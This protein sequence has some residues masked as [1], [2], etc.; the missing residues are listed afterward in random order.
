MG[1]IDGVH[2]PDRD[3][4]HGD[5]KA[6]IP[7]PVIPYS[8]PAPSVLATVVGASDARLPLRCRQAATLAAASRWA[9]RV[10]Y[11]R[12]PLIGATGAVLEH[13]VANV[14]LRADRVGF[15]VVLT[16][17]WRNGAWKADG[18]WILD[19]LIRP[20]ASADALTTLRE[21]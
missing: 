1:L 18:A 19:P 2:Y 15:R 7:P 4:H 5:K 20:V 13:N 3:W 21:G 8:L 14:A 17:A 10:T 9:V 12:G 11:A 6:M 16:W